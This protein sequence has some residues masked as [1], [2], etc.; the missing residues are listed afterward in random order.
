MNQELLRR[1]E[2][3]VSNTK[4]MA[5]SVVID[6]LTVTFMDSG[7]N[8]SEP[9]GIGEC[10]IISEKI[11]LAHQVNDNG[12][13]AKTT[14]QYKNIWHLIY[15]NDH[16]ATI[17]TH[18]C[19]AIAGEKGTV[20]IDFKNHL[21]YSDLWMVYE[22]IVMAF[23]L[24]FKH[25]SRVDIALDGLNYLI[26]FLDLYR[27]QRKLYGDRVLQMKKVAKPS[28]S[29]WNDDKDLFE[30]FIIGKMGKKQISI[31]NKSVE[32]VR[33]GKEYIQ[34]YWLE[35]GVLETLQDLKALQVNLDADIT[36]L[37]GVENVYRF[38]VRLWSEVIR[39]IEGFTIDMLKNRDTLVSIVKSMTGRIFSFKKITS[40][41][42]FSLC[43]NFEVIP[44][45]LFKIHEIVCIRRRAKNN[46]LAAKMSIK[47][48]VMEMYAGLEDDEGYYDWIMHDVT[49]YGLEDWFRTKVTHYWAKQFGAMNPDRAYVNSVTGFLQSMVMALFKR[50]SSREN[51]EQA[52]QASVISQG[53]QNEIFPSLN[54]AR[55]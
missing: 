8:I 17:L 11:V 5:V 48:N 46:V 54:I 22:D 18:P 52:Y 16:V 53:V 1:F 32:I 34:R 2:D 37:D 44:F 42:N 30:G 24:E 10:K 33:S 12:T 23:A 51:L 36:H 38:E 21:L 6:W 35:N 14:R 49:K 20:K 25:V 4:G 15:E 55:C 27:D 50:E 9:V 41:S 7:N 13:A 31:Y 43:P 29:A 40:K 39:E 19:N 47:K 3:M 45:D 26:P 28:A